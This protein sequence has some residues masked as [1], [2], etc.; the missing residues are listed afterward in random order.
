MQ[1]I[2]FSK[3][4]RQHDIF[5]A[6]R[7]FTSLCFTNELLD[8]EDVVNYSMSFVERLVDSWPQIEKQDRSIYTPE[9]LREFV[10]GNPYIAEKHLNE[11]QQEELVGFWLSFCMGYTCMEWPMDEVYTLILHM[12]YSYEGRGFMFSYHP[13]DKQVLQ[14]VKLTD[15]SPEKV[16]LRAR[17]IQDV[18]EVDDYL[19]FYHEKEDERLLN[20]VKHDYFYQDFNP[21]PDDIYMLSHYLISNHLYD[22]WLKIFLSLEV[23]ECQQEFCQYLRSVDDFVNLIEKF[24]VMGLPNKDAYLLILFNK[25]FQTT[26]RKQ[27]ALT[28]KYLPEK[29]INSD[30]ISIWEPIAEDCRQEL[31][32]EIEK[33]IPIFIRLI[34]QDLIAETI[35]SRSLKSGNSV[36]V[37]GYNTVLGKSQEVVATCI[38]PT[39]LTIKTSNLHFLAFIARIYVEKDVFDGRRD[40]LLATIINTISSDDFR[41]FTQLDDTTISD[42]R[43]FSQLMAMKYTIDEEQSLISR[44]RVRY[45]GVNALWLDKRDYAAIH[46]SYILCILLLLVEGNT[47]DLPAKEQHFKM[48]TSHLFHQCHCC[49]WDLIVEQNYYHPLLLAECIAEQI[50]PHLKEAY[51]L[52]LFNYIYEKNVVLNV[53]TA[54]QSPLS[55][56]VKALIALYRKNDW[57]VCREELLHRHQTNVVEQI[58]TIFSKLL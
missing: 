50:L 57:L 21:L 48:L 17:F 33:Y 9:V 3:A 4:I 5:Y 44:F 25:W 42:I 45:E 18:S 43:S 38:D 15:C 28:R 39:T 46:E 34:G 47:L 29:I 30:V 54:S 36:F 56:G 11:H 13:S 32:H 23:P 14:M 49:G 20:K 19:Q 40:A 26:I 55:D 41:L 8:N 12:N 16:L 1:K 22:E 52:S 7:L 51:E 10:E 6:D 53:L 58:E 31:V 37:E 35:C 27:E 2:D 24:S